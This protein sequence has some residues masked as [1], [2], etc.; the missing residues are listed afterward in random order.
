ML[1]SSASLFGLLA[2]LTEMKAFFKL[3]K[4]AFEESRWKKSHMESAAEFSTMALDIGTIPNLVLKQI[5]KRNSER[6]FEG[7]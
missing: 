3:Q 1:S 4:A 5:S 7:F 2:N 6:A